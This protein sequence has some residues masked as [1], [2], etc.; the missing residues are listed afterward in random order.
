MSPNRWGPPIWTFFHTLAEKINE[1][2]FPLVFPAL[3]EFIKRICRIL[4]C[5]DCSQ[6]ATIF[7][8]KVNPEG[9]KCKNDFRNIMCIFHNVVNRRKDKP[10]FN[11]DALS[12]LYGNIGPIAAYNGFV[13][14]FNTKG[15]MKLIA[16]SFQRQ[17]VLADF[18]KWFLT[19]I[20]FFL[21][22]P[23]KSS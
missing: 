17:L 13:S 15:N 8:A 18:R 5:P 12:S 4:P 7:L 3:F 16:D 11:P 1:E 23:A 9:V 19:N 20:R 10:I 2:Q 6:H 21:S 22:Q 14:A